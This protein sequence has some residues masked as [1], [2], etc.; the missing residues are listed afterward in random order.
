MAT[1]VTG[2][3]NDVAE[4]QGWVREEEEG[5]SELVLEL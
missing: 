4:R 3:R 2:Q 1:V 5:G